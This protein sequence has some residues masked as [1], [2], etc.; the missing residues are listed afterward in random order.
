MA[1]W[2]ERGIGF[3]LLEAALYDAFPQ[4]ATREG[5]LRVD[6]GL[7]SVS[8]LSSLR[9]VSGH[10]FFASDRS[11]WLAD[12]LTRRASLHRTPEAQADVQLRPQPR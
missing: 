6:T 5:R 1:K 4:G 9:G 2:R 12:P 3:R 7:W 11:N 8:E 10:V